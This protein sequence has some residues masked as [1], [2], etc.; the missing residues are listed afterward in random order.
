VTDA[1]YYSVAGNV[2][3]IRVP[4]AGSSSAYTAMREAFRDAM[5]NGDLHETYAELRERLNSDFLERQNWRVVGFVR[6]PLAWLDSMVA[7]FWPDCHYAARWFGGGLKRFDGPDLNVN[8][9]TH[10]KRTPYDWFTDA[11]G[12]VCVTEIWRMEDMASF[13]KNLDVPYRH[14]N[15]TPEKERRKIDW[16]PTQLDAIRA[17]FHRELQHY[18]EG[19]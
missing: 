10:M 15:P 12:N 17:R 14:G 4:K 3:L 6:H 11:D 8:L 18:P 5:E 13:C 16:T 1:V 9:L 2:V 19:L 7:Q